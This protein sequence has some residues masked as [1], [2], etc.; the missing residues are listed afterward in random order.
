MSGIVFWVWV[1]DLILRSN[2]F[3]NNLANTGSKLIGR[4]EDASF[5]GLFG[6]YMRI[7]VENFQISRKYDNLSI[8]LYK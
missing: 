5:L 2:I 6:L 7:I 4:Y 1:T 8:E 3:S